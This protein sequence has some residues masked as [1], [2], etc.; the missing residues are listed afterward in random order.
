M[1]SKDKLVTVDMTGSY[2]SLDT[3]DTEAMKRNAQEVYVDIQDRPLVGFLQI[4]GHFDMLKN[5]VNE[6]GDAVQ[7]EY[8]YVLYSHIM[9]ILMLAM[10]IAVF[11]SLFLGNSINF[12]LGA[13]IVFTLLYLS[14]VVVY[15][16]VTFQPNF[17]YRLG[18]FFTVPGYI[19][20]ALFYSNPVRFVNVYLPGSICLL[21]AG[22]CFVFGLSRTWSLNPLS[23][24]RTHHAAWW[25]SVLFAL[26]A[27]F[28]VLAYTGHVTSDRL[29]WRFADDY[30]GMNFICQLLYLLSRIYF[31]LDS[32][33][34]LNEVWI[35]VTQMEYHKVDHAPNMESIDCCRCCALPDR[36]EQRYRKRAYRKHLGLITLKSKCYDKVSYLRDGSMQLMCHLHFFHERQHQLVSKLEV[37]PGGEIRQKKVKR[38]MPE[39]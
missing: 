16:L 20:C 35:L 27:L 3:E 12:N 15:E 32:V 2:H 10:Q 6:V 36:R 5:N 34:A 17:F 25:A 37:T 33:L 21:I 7:A 1:N 18:N 38:G 11:I 26:A 19:M 39:K 24:F 28:D 29:N 23:L 31:F 9:T 13:C 14:L 30:S 8:N 22:I 4:N